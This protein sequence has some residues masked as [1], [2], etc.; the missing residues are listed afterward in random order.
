MNCFNK[1]LFLFLFLL[2]S[3]GPLDKK[4]NRNQYK[5][6]LTEIRKTGAP[7]RDIL[8]LDYYI[9]KVINDSG[10]F[11]EGTTYKQILD[12]ALNEKMKRELSEFRKRDSI[13]AANSAVDKKEAQLKKVINVTLVSVA[14]LKA[15]DGSG[16]FTVLLN[17]QNNENKAVKA[18]KGI[19]S[20]LDPLGEVIK[21]EEFKYD[22]VLKAKELKAY[23]YK[24]NYNEKIEGDQKLGDMESEKIGFTFNPVKIVFTD[25]TEFNAE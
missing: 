4:Y 17:I 6:D 3:C 10:R 21:K 24:M 9:E 14:L 18:F 25:Q 13:T 19:I 11:T 22:A 8:L 5:E 1:K 12:K 7:E 2:V 23:Y 16:E 20:F 15:D